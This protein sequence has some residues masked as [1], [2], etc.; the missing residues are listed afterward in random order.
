MSN[1]YILYEWYKH[2]RQV[3]GVLL[4]QKFSES[5]MDFLELLMSTK[6]K[7]LYETRGRGGSVW[8]RNQPKGIWGFLGEILMQIRLE[9]SI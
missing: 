5:N 9:K 7:N 6:S 2:S 3:M 8:E 4:R 1:I